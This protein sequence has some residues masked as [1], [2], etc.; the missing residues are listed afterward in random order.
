MATL[1]VDFLLNLDSWQLQLLQHSVHGGFT[2]S[3]ACML[4]D[5][6]EDMYYYQTYYLYKDGQFS[7]L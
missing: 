4:S 2:T 1:A 3:W 5:C 6:P 7:Y